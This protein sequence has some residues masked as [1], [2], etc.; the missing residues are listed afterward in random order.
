MKKFKLMRQLVHTTQDYIDTSRKYKIQCGR[1]SNRNIQFYNW[2][3]TDSFD[4]EWFYR[5][6]ENCGLLKN[7]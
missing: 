1:N 6:V 5:F 3:P 2:W 4:R 7:S